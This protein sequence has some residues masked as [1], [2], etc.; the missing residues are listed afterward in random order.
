[1]DYSDGNESSALSSSGLA[2]SPPEAKKSKQSDGN[3][4][5]ASV[6]VTVI[7]STTAIADSDSASVDINNAS[8]G[9]LRISI[10][11]PE[12]TSV[13]GQQLGSSGEAV[14]ADSANTN[15]DAILFSQIGATISK[16]VA[17]QV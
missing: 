14:G 12:A 7:S 8:S 17:L 16:Y 15:T 1:M 2:C 4:N 3:A 6:A 10:A 5:A 9:L 11:V 13:G